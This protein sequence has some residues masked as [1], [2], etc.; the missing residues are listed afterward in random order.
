VIPHLPALAAP[1]CAADDGSLCATVYRVTSSSWLAGSAEWLIAKPL[2]IVLIVVVALVVRWLINR[3]IRRLTRRPATASVPGLLRPL[4]EHAPAALRQAAP[5]L[6]E[7]HRQRAEAVGS[8]LRSSTTV[9]VF[10]V[11]FMLVLSELGINLAPLLASAGI[12]GVAIGFGAQN[13]VKDFLS[14]I[15][16]I[17]E[18]Q[19]G[20]GDVVDVGD[21]IGVVEGVGLRTTRIRDVA[22]AI[23]YVRNGEILRVANKSQG[24]SRVVVDVP[25]SYETDTGRASA[26]LGEVAE[27]VCADPELAGWVLEAPT[28]TG[29]ETLTTDGLTLRVMVKTR[30]DGRDPVA[31][32]LRATVRDRFAAEGFAPPYPRGTMLLDPE[33]RDRPASP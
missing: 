8:V 13:L 10:V 15:S 23:W 7:R 3:A 5:A 21:V 2:T 4:K 32:A 1:S 31:R 29:V 14:G 12:A 18:D 11:A 28:V 33:H 17:L 9:V 26:L 27:Q 6:P 20:V 16:M 22:G 24:W 30:P 25:L 19:Y